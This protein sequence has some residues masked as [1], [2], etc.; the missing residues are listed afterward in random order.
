MR[1]SGIAGQSK[2]PQSKLA[3]VKR[4]AE[5]KY[6]PAKQ[7]DDGSF[8]EK[9]EREIALRQLEDLRTP[10]PENPN[11]GKSADAPST[12]P[13]SNLG[14]ENGRRWFSLKGSGTSTALR[15]AILSPEELTA[16]FMKRTKVDPQACLTAQSLLKQGSRGSYKGVSTDELVNLIQS[17][18]MEKHMESLKPKV[19]ETISD[20]EK[21]REKQL[22]LQQ[23]NVLRYW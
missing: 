4:K 19:E 7:K 16:E 14:F 15:S 20:P 2:I 3:P 1:S 5:S 22:A 12:S 10:K 11:P 21:T 9:Q 23:L 6:Q 13:K 18:Q 8:S 17:K